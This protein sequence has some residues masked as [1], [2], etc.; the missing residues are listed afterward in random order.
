MLKGEGC[1]DSGIVTT[2]GQLNF[3]RWAIMNEVVDFCFANKE[4][5]DKQMELA[6]EKK[7][8]KLFQV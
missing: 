7:Q 2:I 5:I 8:N 6:D 4:N 1:D 3:F